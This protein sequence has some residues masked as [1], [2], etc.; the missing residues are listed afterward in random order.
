MVVTSGIDDTLLRLHSFRYW[1][2]EPQHIMMQL[3]RELL[4]QFT[5]VQIIGILHQPVARIIQAPQESL[6]GAD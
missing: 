2:F 3:L 1:Y 5:G 4:L 6:G